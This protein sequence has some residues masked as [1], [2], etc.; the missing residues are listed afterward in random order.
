MRKPPWRS[1]A[2]PVG[3]ARKAIHA[4]ADRIDLLPRNP[5]SGSKG[6]LIS[7]GLMDGGKSLHEL[8]I[9]SGEW[10]ELARPGKP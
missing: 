4:Q 1:T 6:R 2:R 3:T 8:N 5:W 9:A 7:R 10:L